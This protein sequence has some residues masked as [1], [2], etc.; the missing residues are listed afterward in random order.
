MWIE[1]WFKDKQG[2]SGF[3]NKREEYNFNE[4]WWWE[5][6]WN[7]N[8]YLVFKI[9]NKIIDYQKRTKLENIRYVK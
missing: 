9:R 7:V 2:V 1:R 4:G 5:W 8:E 6:L 3:K